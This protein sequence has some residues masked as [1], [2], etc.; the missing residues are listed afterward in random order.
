[1]EKTITIDGKE[2]RFKTNGATPML[3]K[4][5]F[6]RDLFKDILKMASLEQ[7]TKKKINVEDLEVLDFEVFY[8]MAWLMARTADPTIPDPIKW[9]ESFDE[10]PMVDVMPDLQELL[11]SC[12]MQ[13][14]KKL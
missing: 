7:I 1:M 12:F 14:K 10:F 11:S 13:S 9:L 8:N 3:Y 2:V 5:Q 4:A 6:K